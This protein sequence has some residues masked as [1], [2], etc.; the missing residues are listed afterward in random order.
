MSQKSP[1]FHIPVRILD[2]KGLTLTGRWHDGG[3]IYKVEAVQA[4]RVV[5]VQCQCYVLNGGDQP[6]KLQTS[7]ISA[8]PEFFPCNRA[9]IGNR[10]P[11]ALFLIVHPPVKVQA[12][13]FQSG[14]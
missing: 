7:S 8:M 14:A 2:F 13:S 12:C 6:P 4:R 3:R 11:P 10:T 9:N 5:P 1:A